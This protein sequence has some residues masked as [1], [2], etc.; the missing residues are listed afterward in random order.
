MSD[1][2]L[3]IGRLY[4]PIKAISDTLVGSQDKIFLELPGLVAWYPGGPV[5]GANGDMYNKAT[6]ENV[7]M[8]GTCPVSYDGH[9]YRHTG[10][11]ANY[12]ASSTFPQC[13]GTEAWISSEI[14]GL[15]VGGWVYLDAK[16]PVSS[17]IMSRDGGGSDRAWDLMYVTSSDMF[18]FIVSQT[19]AVINTVDVAFPGL[20]QWV[21]A[22]ARFIPGSE[23]AIWANGA[24]Q[25][26]DTGVVSSLYSPTAD[27]EIGRSITDDTRT[28]DG[29]MRDMFV[30]Q[31][32]LD[33]ETIEEIRVTSAA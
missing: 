25:V 27:F 28:F 23:I 2:A 4:G 32:A 3:E 19:G 14:R 5:E 29:R 15:T 12:F 33:D 17:G 31:A 18:R 21:F 30:C 6:A 13:V 10:N 8:V 11:G 7:A 20:G 9:P 22:A 24:K 1:T 26:L 16:E